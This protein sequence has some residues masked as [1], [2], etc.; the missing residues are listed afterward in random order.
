MTL[1]V[2]HPGALW[3]A[4]AIVPLAV[5]SWFMLSG[6]SRWRRT[7]IIAA[8]ALVIAALAIIL[9]NPAIERSHHDVTVIGVLDISGSVHAFGDLPTPDGGVTEGTVQRMHQWLRTATESREPGDRFGLVV[10]DGRAT[11]IAAPTRGTSG[12]TDLDRIESTGTSIESA[13]RLALALFPTD[14]A[15]RLVL[16]SDGNET[17]GQA[18]DAARDAVAEDGRPIPIDVVPLPYRTVR[19]VQIERI[20]TP[21]AARPGQA[22]TVRIAITATHPATGRLG[23]RREGTAIDLNGAEPGSDRVVHVPAGTSIHRTTVILGDEP[24]SRFR[25]TFVADDRADDVIPSNNTAESVVA[26]PGKGRTLLVNAS[27]DP[28]ASWLTGV[29]RDADLRVDVR[30]PSMLP[31]DPLSLQNYDL[32][33]LDDVPAAHVAPVTQDLLARHV[34]ELGAGLL[35]VGG[36]GSFGAGGWMGTPIAEVLPLELDPPHDVIIPQAALVLVLDRSGSMHQPVAGALATQQEVA[37]HAAMR[38][39]ESLRENSMIGVVAFNRH[40]S[41]IVPLQ[42]NVDRSETAQRVL[43]IEADGG[44]SIIAGLRVA[45]IDAQGR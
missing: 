44:T 36:P 42:Q 9:A 45:H 26:T 32:V 23:L 43:G 37:N 17:A 24:V 4:A 41:V 7:L 21:P 15:R 8:R 33:I 19:D 16:F 25:A 28:S 10:F 20:D 34:T 27:G 18:L 12:A 31:T 2:D 39:I 5:V 29:L 30:A 1:V 38:A 22:I 40:G 13:L 11:T 14:A 35:M 3:I 6:T